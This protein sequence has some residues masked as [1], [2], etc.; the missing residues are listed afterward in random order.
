MLMFSVLVLNT[1]PLKHTHT[2][3]HTQLFKIQECGPLFVRCSWKY[4]YIKTP[5]KHLAPVSA[6]Q[7]DSDRR[8]VTG[9]QVFLCLRTRHCVCAPWIVAFWSQSLAQISR[10]SVRSLIIIIFSGFLWGKKAQKSIT[11]GNNNNNN[12]KSKLI[13]PHTEIL[14]VGPSSNPWITNPIS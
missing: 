4:Q 10:L 14:K 7:G 6:Y 1:V 2:R 3:L 9:W 11:R 5:S 8:D 12:K 13:C